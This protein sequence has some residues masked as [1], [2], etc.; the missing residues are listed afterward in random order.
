MSMI[1]IALVINAVVY[2]AGAIDCMDDEAGKSLSSSG[3]KPPGL[4]P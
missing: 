4:D 3:D 2:M 1:C